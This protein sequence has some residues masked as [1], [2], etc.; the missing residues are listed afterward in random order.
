MQGIEH[1]PMEKEI[2]LYE[3]FIN[4]SGSCLSNLCL[5][6]WLVTFTADESH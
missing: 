4:F 3:L 1:C 6:V 5:F 2:K